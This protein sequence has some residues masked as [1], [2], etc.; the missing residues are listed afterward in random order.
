MG[1]L[2]RM[3]MQPQ[4]NPAT[5]C[6][7]KGLSANTRTNPAFGRRFPLGYVRTARR[8]RPTDTVDAVLQPVNPGFV[9]GAASK[10]TE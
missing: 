8:L 9:D 6:E 3:N 2:A 7:A 1:R 4:K 5:A 10:E